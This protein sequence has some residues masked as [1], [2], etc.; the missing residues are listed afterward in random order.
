MAQIP[1]AVPDATQPLTEDLKCTRCGYNLRGLTLDKLCPECG[2]AIARSV[3]GNLLRYADPEWLGKLRLGTA[4]MLWTILI[5]VI[6]AVAVAAITALALPIALISLILL[7]VAG[8]ELW[9]MFLI[10]TPE[11]TIA[12]DEDPITLRRLVR[13]CAVSN[14]LGTALQEA[15]E[16]VDLGVAVLVVGGILALV[17]VVAHFGSFVYYRRFA[18]RIPNEHLAGQTRVVMWGFVAGLVLVVLT[19][20]V[21]AVTLGLTAAAGGPGTVTV[22]TPPGVPAGQGPFGAIGLVGLGVFGCGAGIALVVFG[23]WY[24]VLLF[25]YH[26]AFGQALAEARQTVRHGPPAPPP[27][28]G[29]SEPGPPC[30]S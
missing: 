11:P 12:F 29:V 7:V 26:A 20:I 21:A 5:S 10:T 9:A 22:A 15:A 30:T 19:G 2:T 4:L 27:D 24:V 3:H 25:R 17:G 16:N 23:I 14:F 28:L 13:I 6:A 18:L 8:L 1:P